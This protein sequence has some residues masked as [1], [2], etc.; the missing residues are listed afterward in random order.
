MNPEMQTRVWKQ[1]DTQTCVYVCTL[2]IYKYIYVHYIVMN[3]CVCVCVYYI[4]INPDIHT[5]VQRHTDLR[6]NKATAVH[7]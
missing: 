1:T 6:N 7:M 5:L 4:A 2:Y 3:M